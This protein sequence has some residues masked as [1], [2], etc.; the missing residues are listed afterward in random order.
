MEGADIGFVH[1]GLEIQNLQNDLYIFGFRVAYYG[2][3]IGL[4]MLAG[5]WM[6]QSDAKRRGQDPEI[7]L[8]F[9]LY[10]IIFSI[11]GAR[12]YYVVFQWDSYKKIGRAHV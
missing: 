8:D 1:L 3:I 2:I 9:A 12:L 7:Y 10:G 4:G 6:A 5:I 11:I